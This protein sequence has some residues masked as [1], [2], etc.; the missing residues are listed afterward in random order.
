MKQVYCFV[1]SPKKGVF[2]LTKRELNIIQ[3]LYENRPT[4]E[5]IATLLV[6]GVFMGFLGPFDTFKLGVWQSLTYWVVMCFVG[7]LIFGPFIL[8]GQIYGAQKG[9]N[10]YLTFMAVV[11]IGAIPM[12]FAVALANSLFFQYDI[13][14][15]SNLYVYYPFVVVVGFLVGGLSLLH[16]KWKEKNKILDNLPPES[17]GQNFLKRLPVELGQSLI[18]F[19]MEDHYLRIY[20]EKGEHMLLHRLKDA[21]NE[22]GDYDGMQVHR[23]WWISA[24]AVASVKREGRKIILVMKNGLEIP[25]SRPYQSMVR[26]RFRD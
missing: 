5:N 8:L 26:K 2:P 13:Y 15:I 14:N 24:D 1:K 19:V 12:T 11:I 3:A 18:C 17:P 16:K 22:L 21:L 9:Y 6:I 20:T 4:L 25:V 23:S 7:Y 10:I